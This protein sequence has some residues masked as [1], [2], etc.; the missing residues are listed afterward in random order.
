MKQVLDRLLTCTCPTTD[1]CG[2][3]LLGGAQADSKRALG[4]DSRHVS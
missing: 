4:G 3:R 1:D 2:L